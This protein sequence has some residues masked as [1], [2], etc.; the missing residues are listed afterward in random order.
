[1][2]K[3]LLVLAF[4]AAFVA[5]GAFVTLTS[6]RPDVNADTTRSYA[7]LSGTAKETTGQPVKAS[8]DVVAEAKVV[9]VQNAALSLRA[10]GNVAEVLISEGGRVE[11]GQV[12]LRLEAGQQAAAVSQAEAELASA[13][14][15][16]AQLKSG[17]R[18]QELDSAQADL[19]AARAN[20]AKVKETVKPE[21]IAAAQARVVAAQAALKK[22]LDGPEENDKIVAKAELKRAEVALQEAQ[23]NYD[24]IK[25]RNDLGALP[26]AVE[27]QRATIDRE[28]A[29]AA[30]NQATQDPTDADI[31]AARSELAGAQ[32]NLVDV[33][34][35]ASQAEIDSSAAEVRR[36]EAQ[37]ALLKAGERPEAVA[38]QQAAVDGAKAALQQA[39]VALAETELRAPF[40]G[41]VA[42]L[43]V[44][45]GEHVTA[46]T[47]IVHLADLSRLQIET[48][49][50][51]ELG[52]VRVKPG[53]F[54][55]I[56]VDALPGAEFSG[57]VTRI[58][59]LGENK[60]GD[61]VYTVVVDP[62]QLDQR[63]RWNMTTSVA[64][65]GE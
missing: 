28:K 64:I 45:V 43:D 5:G 22:V 8:S 46:G 51:T 25:Y 52:I 58:K 35:G 54:V 55:S 9:P 37:L 16:L 41:I 23:A 63:L 57:K 60:Q 19:D 59:P 30:Y 1:M 17:A 48:S 29:L 53:A 14:A 15:Q 4:I 7:A 38:V 56:T 32:A 62:D 18:P 26:Q 31:T 24:P 27:L 2:K 20:L 65:K 34:K 6:G 47:P 10:T 40:N 11:A 21:D 39:Q 42:G 44:K 12:I 49:D 36:A 61:I 13:Q 50:L 33:R 3:I